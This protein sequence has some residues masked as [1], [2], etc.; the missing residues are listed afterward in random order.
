MSA[1]APK[2]V[3]LAGMNCTADLWAE[4]GFDT[5]DGGAIQPQLDRPSLRTQVDSLLAEMP[6]QSVIVGHSLG[7][8]VGMAL[9]LAAP[10]RVAGLCLVSTNAK[11]PTDAQRGGWRNWLAALDAGASA[12]ALQQSIL[13][14]LLGGRLAAERPDLVERALRMGD[15]T[16][17]DL[18]RRQ[19][20]LQLTR[21]DL[22]SRL[23]S[24]RMPTL[25]VSGLDDVICPPHFHT[26]IVTEIDGARLVSLDAGHLLPLERPREF[27]DLVRSWCAQRVR[28]AAVA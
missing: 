2:L 6:A 15:E 9:A 8:I 26:E 14:P 27:G 3:L 23:S 28:P 16:G 17:D 18:L 22:L 19:L 5:E 21:V 10:H 11:A 12:R 7:G 13:E 20:Q 4:A 25:V 1:S 24:L